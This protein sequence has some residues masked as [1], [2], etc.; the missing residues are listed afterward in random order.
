MPRLDS[1]RR[2][3][4]A[5]WSS[6][7]ETIG[8]SPGMLLAAKQMGASRSLRLRPRA[9][10]TSQVTGSSSGNGFL[11]PTHKRNAS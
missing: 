1:A 2:P 6:Q 3:G 7:L 8:C 11:S 4:S 10:G 9:G 5:A